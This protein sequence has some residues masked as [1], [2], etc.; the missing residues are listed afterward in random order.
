[1]LKDLKNEIRGYKTKYDK[2]LDEFN[3]QKQYIDE[4]YNK[5]ASKWLEEYA[6]AKQL[7]DYN[8]KIMREN[9]IEIVNGRIDEVINK[10]KDKITTGITPDIAAELQILKIVKVNKEELTAYVEKY[11]YNYLICK[12]LKEIAEENKID[13]EIESI[14]DKV[15]DIEELRHMVVE[16]FNM[17]DGEPRYKCELMIN[18]AI[19]DNVSNRLNSF[20]ESN[21][22][23]VI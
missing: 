23:R 8:V 22:T 11:K 13:I 19:I 1:M 7:F 15:E 2:Q 14:Q 21:N 18:G 9:K 16:F 3:K 6:K 4:I 17:Y 5:G 10:L 12:A 20:F